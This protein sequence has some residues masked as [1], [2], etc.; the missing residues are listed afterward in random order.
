MEVELGTAEVAGAA[1]VEKTPEKRSVGTAEVAGAG[2]GGR[3]GG[4]RRIGAGGRS[5]ERL[6]AMLIWVRVSQG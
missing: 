6:E 2:G 1:E 3:A 4:G 5:R